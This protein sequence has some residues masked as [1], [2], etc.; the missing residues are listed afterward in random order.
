VTRVPVF[1]QPLETAADTAGVIN[2]LDTGRARRPNFEWNERGALLML[3]FFSRLDK[4]AGISPINPIGFLQTHPHP[5]FRI[6]VVQF[7]AQSWHQ[8]HPG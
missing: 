7:V 3:D 8:T 5:E 2:V 1:N 6:P 4:A